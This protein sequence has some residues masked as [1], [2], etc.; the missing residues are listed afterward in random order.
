MCFQFSSDIGI[1]RGY[2]VAINC[3]DLGFL[4]GVVRWV[5]GNKVG[6]KLIPSSNTAAQIRAWHRFF[7]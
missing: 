1:F 2:E 7:R 5:R 3:E 4:H 6:I